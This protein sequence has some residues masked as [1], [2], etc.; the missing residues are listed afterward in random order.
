MSIVTLSTSMPRSTTSYVTVNV[1]LV[2]DVVDQTP[3]PLTKV[4]EPPEATVGLK[5]SVGLAV[6]FA[7]IVSLKTTVTVNLSTPTSPSSSVIGFAV[8]LLTVG[9]TASTVN[10][11]LSSMGLVVISGLPAT[12]AITAPDGIRSLIVP[13]VLGVTGTVNTPEAVSVGVPIAIVAPPAPLAM[14]F[15]K[16]KFVTVAASMSSLNV[17][18]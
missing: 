10:V 16:S 17:T 11:S 6:P 13:P 8:T 12:S 14:P 3:E 4:A 5:T 1:S 2:V 9:D 18:V 15:T 7:V